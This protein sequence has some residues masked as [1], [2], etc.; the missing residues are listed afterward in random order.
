MTQRKWPSSAGDTGIPAGHKVFPGHD[1][2]LRRGI[3]TGTAGRLPRSERGSSPT[4]SKERGQG[5]ESE[6]TILTMFGKEMIGMNQPNTKKARSRRT[7]AEALPIWE[8]DDGH[9]GKAP[10]EGSRRVVLDGT[11]YAVLTIKNRNEGQGARL[12]TRMKSCFH[13]DRANGAADFLVK[14]A[15]PA[16]TTATWSIVTRGVIDLSGDP[17][18]SKVI[19]WSHTW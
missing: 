4:L 8:D 17:I 12:H 10:L 16:M 7:S 19:E 14:Y 15:G 6:H 13:I 11:E 1:S 3:L 5:V 9:I 2:P 18:G